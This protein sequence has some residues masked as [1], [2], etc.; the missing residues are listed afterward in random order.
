MDM[1]FHLRTSE[2]V[3]E[4]SA[5]VTGLHFGKKKGGCDSYR[6][7]FVVNSQTLALLN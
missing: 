3:F 7:T 6:P 5:K 1:K 2:C 4:G